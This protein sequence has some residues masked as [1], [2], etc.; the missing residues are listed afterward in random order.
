MFF[1]LE[2][3]TFLLATYLKTIV[4]TTSRK[5]SFFFGTVASHGNFLTPPREKCILPIFVW[6]PHFCFICPFPSD[7]CGLHP[8]VASF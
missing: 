3:R 4:R 1:F 7:I 2:Y 8:N 6:M 5:K